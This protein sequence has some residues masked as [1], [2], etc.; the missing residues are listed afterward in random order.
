MLSNLPKIILLVSSGGGSCIGG[1]ASKPLLLTTKFVCLPWSYVA[2]RG[3]EMFPGSVCG[4]I[5]SF[6]VVDEVGQVAECPGDMM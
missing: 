5:L 1:L 3:L 6:V 2:S 4:G